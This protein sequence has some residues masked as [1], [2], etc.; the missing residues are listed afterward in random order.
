MRPIFL[1]LFCWLFTLVVAQDTSCTL[2]FYNVE[3]Y[4]DCVDDSLTND[5]DFLPD[6]P[7][8]WT[9]KRYTAKRQNIARVIA[10]VGQGVPPALV[11][12]C[13]VEN[14]TVLKELV[15]YKPLSTY[16]YKTIH[17]ESP[18]ARGIDVALLYQSRWFTPLKSEPIRVCFQEAGCSRDILYVKGLLAGTDTLHVMVCHAP[19]R[20]GG[21]Q[22]NV[23]R[24]QALQ[25]VRNVADSIMQQ[26]LHASVLIMGDFNDTPSDESILHTLG[27]VPLAQ[28]S[29]ST[30]LVNIM[31]HQG[32]TYKYKAEWSLFDQFMVSPELLQ[33]DGWVVED[34]RG[35]IFKDDFL[36]EA[37]ATHMG[38][39]PYRTY[40]GP[41]YIGGYSD[42]LPIFLRL[43]VS[44]QK[45]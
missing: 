17:Y 2:M 19:S 10:A 33:G 27:A 18:D 13:E 23:R 30:R 38:Y 9:W 39:K 29:D 22:A 14:A 25:L 44:Q 1:F 34:K 37:D 32:G 43:Q 4:F 8:H 31:P 35:Y 20:R 45:K 12:L 36:L 6:A 7:K 26:S 40:L 24:K 11:G 28:T 15:R 42:H 3:N 5:N 16:Q 21:E 41:R